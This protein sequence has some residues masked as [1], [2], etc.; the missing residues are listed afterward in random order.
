MVKP[1]LLALMPHPIALALTP[2]G[3]AVVDY[4]G[5]PGER[6]KGELHLIRGVGSDAPADAGSMEPARPSWLL[7]SGLD[8]PTG[9][10]R[11]P[12][13]RWV[14]AESGHSRIKILTGRRA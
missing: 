13:G 12:D 2:D 11:L 5:A 7:A 3:L 8:G 9:L 10:A 6:G 14:V 1:K 4:G